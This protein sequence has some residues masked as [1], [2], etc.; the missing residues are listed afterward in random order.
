MISRNSDDNECILKLYS[1][2]S[3]GLYIILGIITSSFFIIRSISESCS[4]L[5]SSFSSSS[6]ITLVIGASPINYV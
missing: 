1:L 2:L 4:L 6:T 5:S 3:I